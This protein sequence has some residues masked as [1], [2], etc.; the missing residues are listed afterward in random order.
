M[1][2]S[3]HGD[4]DRSDDQVEI[5][6][7]DPQ[8]GRRFPVR[9]VLLGK[10]VRCSRCKCRFIAGAATAISRASDKREPPETSGADEDESEDG[11]SLVE[12]PPVARTE[13]SIDDLGL[14]EPSSAP[15]RTPKA[16]GGVAEETSTAPGFASS[17]MA[18]VRRIPAEIAEWCEGRSWLLRAALLAYLAHVGYKYLG[19]HSIKY[20][21][22]EL[23][24]YRSA[25]PFWLLDA[26]VH[27]MG[28][29]LFIPIQAFVF[30]GPIITFVAVAAGT[31]AQ[32]GLPFGACIMFWRQSDYFAVTVGGVWFATSLYFTQWYASDARTQAGVGLKIFGDT[33][34]Y[35]HD[36]NYMFGQLGLLE[37][38]LI[39]ARILRVISFLIMWSSIAAGAWMVLL[40]IRSNLRQLRD[41][42]RG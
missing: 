25:M 10:K 15:G 41:A 13:E 12:T 1:P 42:V 5:Q 3:T 7:P 40:M 26:T 33:V 24:L 14:I 23:A 9:P 29:I 21:Y 27:E 22:G 20:P 17:V 38:D 28:H 6:C 16:C 39:I 30:S 34:K 36:F 11:L 37:Y 19:Y 4:T 32:L 18:R 8:C 2:S 35:I 31:L